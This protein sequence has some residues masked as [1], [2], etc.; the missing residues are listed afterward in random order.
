MTVE[1]TAARTPRRSAGNKAGT[2]GTKRTTSTTKK[3][4]GAGKSAEP[5]LVQLLTPEGKRRLPLRL[6]TAEDIP[7]LTGLLM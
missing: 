1:S 5:A 4:T 2:T 7:K 6:A 3:A